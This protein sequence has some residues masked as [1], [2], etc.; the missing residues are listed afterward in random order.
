M[1]TN[2]YEMVGN[3]SAIY[4]DDL[5][6]I[7]KNTNC[8]RV[9]NF[10]LYIDDI[11]K[12][13]KSLVYNNCFFL[14]NLAT[15]DFD[16]DL[17][18]EGT[19]FVFFFADKIDTRQYNLTTYFSRSKFANAIRKNVEM[20]SAYGIYIPTIRI[21]SSN[22]TLSMLSDFKLYGESHTKNKPNIII[23]GNNVLIE[24]EQNY[25]IKR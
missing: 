25:N 15:S 23:T 13:N 10:V 21:K 17:N 6:S 8:R 11:K 9:N 19:M 24:N 12:I 14:F 4:I 1:R 3:R 22:F 18:I 5:N 16:I 2:E 20:G 7:C